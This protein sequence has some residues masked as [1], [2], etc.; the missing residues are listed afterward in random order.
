MRIRGAAGAVFVH[1]AHL[2][3]LL[4]SIQ[5]V[6]EQSGFLRRQGL[7]SDGHRLRELGKGA[8]I[9]GVGLG[10]LAGGFREIA[11]TLGLDDG[12]GDGGLVK[13]DGGGQFKAAGAF[14][15]DE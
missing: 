5:E 8:G 10:E 13:G 6:A 14:E 1:G 7:H 9:N 3:E 11:G 2:D 4:A 15:D 12:G